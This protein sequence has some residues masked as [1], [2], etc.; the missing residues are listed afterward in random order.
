VTVYHSICPRASSVMTELF[1][2]YCE[3]TVSDG[4][5]LFNFVVDCCL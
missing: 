5:C 4:V 1:F 2:E 3:S